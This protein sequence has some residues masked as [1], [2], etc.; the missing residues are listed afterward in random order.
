MDDLRAF[1]VPVLILSGGEPLLHPDLLPIARRAKQGFCGPVQNGT[2]IDA[3]NIG[4]LAEVGFDYVGVSLD[5]LGASHDRFRRQIG[6]FDAA[7]AGIRLCVAAGL[8]VGLRFTLTQD[9]QDLPALL[10]LMDEEGLE[11]FYL[12]HL[13]YAGCGDPTGAMT[14]ATAS[15]ATPWSC[16]SP[17]PGRMPNGAEP[18]LRDRQQRR[19]RRLSAALAGRAA[20][21]SDA[22]FGRPAGALGRQRLRRQHRR[23]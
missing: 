4:A 13:N 15:P 17:P 5:G 10:K 21:G 18:G 6:A 19:G 1:G 12:S 16:C 2:L 22:T 14:P 11:K 8:K 7:L 3:G 20:A 23:T 9:A